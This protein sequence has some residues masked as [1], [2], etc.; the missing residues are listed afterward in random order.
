MRFFPPLLACVVVAPCA[1][2]NA[3]EKPLAGLKPTTI[4]LWPGKP[5]GEA[6]AVAETQEPDQGDRVLRITNVGRPTMTVYPV[7]RSGPRAPAVLVCP[8][9]GYRILAFDKEGTEIARWLNSMGLAAAVLKYRVPDNRA[10]ALADAQRALGV[11]RCRA[12]EWNIDTG[13]IGVIGFSAGGHLA[14][15]LSNDN[16]KRL[17]SEMDEADRL[18]CRPDFTILVYP[19]YLSG[20]DYRLVDEVA[21]TTEAPPAFLVQTQDDRSYIDSSIAYYLALKK[22]GVAGELHL[23]PAGGHGYALRPTKHAVSRWPG[24]CEAWLR[25]RGVLPTKK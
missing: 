20:K 3:A 12:H 9:G 7:N 25:E 13:R 4:V 5:P 21:I 14:A 18:S 19:A 10:G 16:K 6:T 2:V 8:G 22:A 11:L 15:R 24:L 1:L 23:F 17:Y